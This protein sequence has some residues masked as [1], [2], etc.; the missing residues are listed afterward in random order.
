MLLC[1]PLEHTTRIENSVSK[2]FEA[3]YNK[4]QWADGRMA[5]LLW[6]IP[7]HR[8]YRDEESGTDGSSFMEAR[9]ISPS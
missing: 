7:L 9:N 3:S 5:D 6:E 2:P 4:V 8:S 1:I